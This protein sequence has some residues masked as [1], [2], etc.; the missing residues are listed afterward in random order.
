MDDPFAG[1][2]IDAIVNKRPKRWLSIVDA[3]LGVKGDENIA[4]EHPRVV[5]QLVR[6]LPVG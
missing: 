1:M 2:G 5:L 6:N 3:S 4:I